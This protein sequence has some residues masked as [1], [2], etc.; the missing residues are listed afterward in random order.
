ML[1]NSETL[2]LMHCN[3]SFPNEKSLIRRGN[4]EAFQQVVQEYL[5]LGHAK[6]VPFPALQLS[7]E[8]SYYMAMHGVVKESSSTT[9][10]RVVFDTSAK[11]TSGSSFNDS[12]SRSYIVSQYM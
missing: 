10:L 5:D 9:K 8:K 6:L 11:T 2:E 3:G 4:W 12:H 7:S 1:Q